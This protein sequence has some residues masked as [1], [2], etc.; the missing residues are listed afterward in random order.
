M[1]TVFVE[2]LMELVEEGELEILYVEVGFWGIGLTELAIEKLPIN[3]KNT[4]NNCEN[5]FFEKTI[6]A[7]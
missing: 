2:A 7:W 6:V 1:L 3:T 4:N 5:Q